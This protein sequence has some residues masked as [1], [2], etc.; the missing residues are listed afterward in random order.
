VLEERA[1]SAISNCP[2]CKVSLK[3]EARRKHVAKC[4]TQSQEDR[5]FYVAHRQWPSK[6]KA[7]A[8]G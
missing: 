6:R 4:A 2:H 1:A 5:A 8:H 7:A 3:A